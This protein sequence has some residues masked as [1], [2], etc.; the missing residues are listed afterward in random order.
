MKKF[1]TN[2]YG[3]LHIQHALSPNPNPQNFKRHCHSDYELIYVAQGMGK[4]VVE[5][6]EYPLLPN[7]VLLLR[8]YE[9]HYVCP[10]SNHAYER[11]VIHFSEEIFLDATKTL[12]ILYDR[13]EGAG[14]Y[15]PSEVIS[16]LILAQFQTVDQDFVSD[17][18]RSSALPSR[19]ETVLRT[20]VNQILLFLSYLQADT[21]RT[22]ENKWVGEVIRYLGENISSSIT[23]E[24]T[25]KRFFVSK[26]HL[27]HAFRAHTGIS[28]FSYLTTKRIALAEQLLE[29][30]VPATE[31]ALQVGFGD[32]STFYRAYRKQ[33][34]KSPSEIKRRLHTK[35]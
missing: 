25:A 29:D 32:Y 7:T 11:Y 3:H 24:E 21:P 27:C 33:M 4:Y 35:A 17:G 31:V 1:V 8:P 12:S 13:Q 5:S 2:Q 30:G 6:M 10:Q 19:S 23:L 28:V 20:S 14:V 16:P 9:Y 26:Y 22:H 18:E 15:F 34:G